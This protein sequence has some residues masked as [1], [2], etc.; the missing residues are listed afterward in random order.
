MSD[1]AIGA[2]WTRLREQRRTALIPYLTAGHPDRATSLAA[3]NMV[4]EAGA[5]FL[6]LGIPFSDPLADGPV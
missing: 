6:E 1:V 4:V 5:D 3:M 2:R